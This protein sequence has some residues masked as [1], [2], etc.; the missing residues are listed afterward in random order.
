M[1][2]GRRIQNGNNGSV[3]WC[4]LSAE[5]V[6]TTLSD[7]VRLNATVYDECHRQAL[8]R[9]GLDP[10]SE[11]DLALVAAN[12]HLTKEL[13][14]VA[15]ALLEQCAVKAFVAL[16]EALDERVHREKSNGFR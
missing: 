7:N 8:A 12:P 16:Q 14:E 10:D 6:A 15:R 1:K 11:E 2:Y 13:N 4:E 9:R 3:Q 5:E